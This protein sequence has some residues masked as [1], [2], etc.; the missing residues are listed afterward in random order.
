MN[1]IINK[2]QELSYKK[3]VQLVVAVLLT[4]ALGIAI[5]IYAWFAN[6]KKA[7]ELYKIEYPNSLYLNA[8]HREDRMY[9]NLDELNLDEY[10]MDD[11][12]TPHNYG[13][14]EHPEY[15]E[16]TSRL[17]AFSVSGEGITSF[18]L[19]LAHTNNNKLRYTVYEATETGTKP[20]SGDENFDYVHY[21]RHMGEGDNVENPLTFS[22]DL[23]GIKDAY[24]TKGDQISLDF[25]N[26]DL[27]D[28]DGIL[29]L[30][31]TT[32]KYYKKTYG[33]TNVNV[34]AHAVPS[35]WQ[36]NIILSRTDIDPNSK[37]F[38]KY[39]ILEVSWDDTQG[40]TKETD[41]IY[42]AVRRRG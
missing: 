34:Q 14:P 6:Q 13:T 7:A 19:Q 27:T 32:D 4:V 36:T 20:A 11:D 17:Y 25:K 33:E 16:R 1:K 30:K 8:A 40:N 10:Y 12:N 35:Y 41:M 3:K 24:Y 22:D 42:L 29:A 9:F 37:Q 38:C 2:I 18:T 31:N 5:P 39:F 21:E 23:V 15:R 26:P 28:S